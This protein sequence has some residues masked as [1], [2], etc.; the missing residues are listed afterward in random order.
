VELVY[1]GATAGHPWE[2][3][4]AALVN[5][6]G[7]VAALVFSGAILALLWALARIGM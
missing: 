2:L 4:H 6:A 7:F 5:V 1:A 3:N